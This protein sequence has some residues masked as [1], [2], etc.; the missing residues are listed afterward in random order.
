MA[1]RHITFRVVTGNP[2]GLDQ[3]RYRHPYAMEIS[4]DDE[5]TTEQL[6]QML[7]AEQFINKSD[8]SHFAFRLIPV[9]RRS[10]THQNAHHMT[11]T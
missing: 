3:N 10:L 1:W 11:Q 5:L 4:L 9:G 8:A 6:I 7:V 2:F